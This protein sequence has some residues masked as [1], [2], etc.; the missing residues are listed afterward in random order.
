M[1]KMLKAPKIT[2][3]LLLFLVFVMPA[4]AQK[5][6]K[7]GTVTYTASYELSPDKQQ[8]ADMLPKEIQCYFRGDSTAAVVNQGMATVKG[9]SVF[10]SDYHSLI[11]DVPANGKKILVVL[12][13]DE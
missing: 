12:T 4:A 8:Y 5:K 7:E 6:I 3:L 2:L 9:V 13:P 1:L 11:I 10:K